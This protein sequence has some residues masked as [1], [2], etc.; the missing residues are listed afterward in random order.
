MIMRDQTKTGTQMLSAIALFCYS[1]SLAALFA[2]GYSLIAFAL[3]VAG[4]QIGAIYSSR[5]M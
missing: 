2:I 1:A 5:G 3:D 4:Q